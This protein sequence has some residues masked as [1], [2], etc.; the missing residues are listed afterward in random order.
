VSD[1][2]VLPPPQCAQRLTNTQVAE[3][4]IVGLVVA[5]V[6]HAAEWRVAAECVIRI[7]WRFHPIP[8]RDCGQKP[9]ARVA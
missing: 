2:R 5:E 9:A 3:S 8:K 4:R 7:R 1:G 6:P